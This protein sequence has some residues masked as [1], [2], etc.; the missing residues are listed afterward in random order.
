MNGESIRECREAFGQQTRFLFEG[1]KIVP[2]ID[3][4]QLLLRKP[5]TGDLVRAL[6]LLH[7]KMHLQ[8]CQAIQ[9][10][11]VIRIHQ[12]SQAAMS[13]IQSSGV[14]HLISRIDLAIDFAATA[15]QLNQFQ[16]FFVNHITQPWHG[17]RRCHP[18]RDTTYY[19]PKSATR[20]IVI[21][22]AIPSKVLGCETLHVE[23]RLKREA[24]RKAVGVVTISDVLSALDVA[25]VLDRSCRLSTM[26]SAA[27]ERYIDK[28]AGRYL[29]NNRNRHGRVPLRRTCVARKIRTTLSRGLQDAESVPLSESISKVPAQRWLEIYPDIANSASVHLAATVILA[30]A[31]IRALDDKKTTKRLTCKQ[32]LSSSIDQRTAGY[33]S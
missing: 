19:A 5:L 25:Q 2:Y 3:T 9:F 14:E 11:H 33:P 28:A 8:R 6:R 7:P 10:P 15:V 32:T 31:N 30:N 13:L 4:I 17:K 21:Y 12:P 27:I 1:A 16:Q 26:S 22:R 24:A 23:I 20:N 29:R 18:F